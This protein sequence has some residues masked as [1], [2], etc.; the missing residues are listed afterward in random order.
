MLIY[1][2]YQAYLQL[3]NIVASVSEQG[4]KKQQQVLF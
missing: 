1:R 3:E 4:R 2:E